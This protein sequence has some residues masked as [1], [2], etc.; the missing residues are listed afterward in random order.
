MDDYCVCCGKSVPEMCDGIVR[1]RLDPFQIE[2]YGVS[3][4]IYVCKTK[5]WQIADDI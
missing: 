5:Y 2:I 4:E 1:K 3:K